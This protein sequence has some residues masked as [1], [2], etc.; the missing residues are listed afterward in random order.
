MLFSTD[1][2]SIHTE[3][4]LITN[5]CGCA[6]NEMMY[7]FILFGKSRTYVYIDDVSMTDT[8]ILFTVITFS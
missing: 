6:A 1:F 8:W 4:S 2:L 7:K 3:L 5:F